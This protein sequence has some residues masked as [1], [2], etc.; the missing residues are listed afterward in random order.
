MGMGAFLGKFNHLFTLI[1]VFPSII[2][3]GLYL[4]WH[5]RFVQV[6]QLKKS[7]LSLTKKNTV[8]EGNISRFGAIASVLA[9][10]L[11]TGN[12]SGMAVAITTGGPGALV[13]MWIMVFFG[14]AIQYAS[15]VLGM[16]YRLKMRSGEYVGGPM[17]YLRDG[18]G[19]KKTAMLF[20]VLV[21]FGSVA[22]GNLAQIN[23]IILPLEKAGLDP[24]YS[25]L[26]IAVIV[27]L[28]VLGGIERISTLASYAVPFKAVLYLG[29]AFVILVFHYEKVIP[30]FYLMFQEAFGF[31]A[32]AGGF[33]GAGVLKAITIGFDRGLFAT[34]AG[35][36]IVPILQ[37][38]AKS[39]H[40]VLDGISS[41]IAPL[42]V[43]IVC[44]ATGLVLIV[45][46]AWQEMGLK[47]TNLVTHAFT[48]GL[49]N[50]IGGYI[51]IASLILFAFTTIMAW[52]YCGEKA[53][54]FLTTPERA[55]F[56]RYIFIAI[57]PIGSLLHVEMV[58]ILADLA[59]SSML[60]INLIGIVALSDQVI[61]SSEAYLQGITDNQELEILG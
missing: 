8:S 9:G 39:E 45:T 2:F 43:M 11:G 16:T 34:D 47:S 49:G 10:N 23:S 38:S 61:D 22:I 20:A 60:T 40:P 50:P 55:H 41:L 26:V 25:S 29:T 12:I 15:C 13:W 24:L 52:C 17:Y 32:L 36:G 18:L 33:L 7:F 37:A 31:S 6:L 44:T 59:V 27:G 19:Y 53:L 46:G 4:T 5:L 56:F 3:I 58:W 54:G 48:E 51:V 30:A 35:L 21:L 57:I 14:S 28:V 1:V 42:I